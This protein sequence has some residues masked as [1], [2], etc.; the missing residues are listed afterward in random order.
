[1]DYEICPECAYVM[2]Y[3]ATD[4]GNEEDDE[5]RAKLCEPWDGGGW[6]VG[7]D[8]HWG[9]TWCHVCGDYSDTY[10]IMEQD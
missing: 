1:M 2:A 8:E 7:D 6:T 5:R 3:G 4:T 10:F 9:G